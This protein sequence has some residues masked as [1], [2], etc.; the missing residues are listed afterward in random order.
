MKNRGMTIA[1]LVLIAL[2]GLL[3]W[4]NRHKPDE[5]SLAS[6]TP[7][8]AAPKILTVNEADI[9]KI[10]LTKKTGDQITLTKDSVGAWK[11]TAPQSLPVDQSVVSGMLSTLSS[12]NSDR[13]VEDKATN[14]SRYGLSNAA[15]TVV[16]TDK[17]NSTH[18][19]LIGDD[20]PTGNAAYANLEGDPR[21]FTIAS[22]TKTSVDK[23]VD[24]LRDKRLITYEPDK[25]TRVELSL[26]GAQLEF[27]RDKDQW[28]IVKPKPMRADATKVDDLVRKLTDAKMEASAPTN[29]DKDKTKPEDAF[30]AG[31]LV[32]VAKVTSDAGTQQLEVRKAKDDYYAKSSVTQGVHK[33]SAD[34]GQA[35]DKKWEE[36]RDKK[37]F[38]SNDPTKIEIHD[39]AKSYFLT[40]DG[41]DWWDAG[42][43]KLDRA[44]AQA[45]VDQLRDLQATDF[46][47]SGFG[48]TVM[49]ITVTSNDGKRVEKT[50]ISKSDKSPLAKR[51][52]EATLYVLESG[53]IDNLQ[54]LLNDLK[55]EQGGK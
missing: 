54:K 19:L 32:S 31:S 12:L 44:G 29:T 24:D 7:A 8:E 48:A 21:V 33:V 25:I 53:A 1:A 50:L 2:L 22:F 28:Q 15:V 17:N 40:K 51:E 41:D 39:G 36:F 18:K 46:A 34:L 52:G 4:S 35:L 30:A 42:G 11:I 45:L 27:G 47:E 49:H 9:T 3:Y 43:K 16:I 26:K 23:N 14:L 5:S 10:E 38:S 13:L 20:T 6:S 37:L 55:P